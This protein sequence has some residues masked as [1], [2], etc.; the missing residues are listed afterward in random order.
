MIETDLIADGIA[1]AL[2]QA[3]PLDLFGMKAAA[4]VIADT[5]DR[6]TPNFNRLRFLKIAGVIG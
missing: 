5:L 3:G 6:T 2:T 4:E 1:R